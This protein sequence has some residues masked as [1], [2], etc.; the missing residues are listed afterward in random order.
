MTYGKVLEEIVTPIQG[1]FFKNWER[2]SKIS[3]ELFQSDLKENLMQNLE[4]FKKILKKKML[5][6]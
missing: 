1:K 5:Q 2:C 4:K 6:D 3:R